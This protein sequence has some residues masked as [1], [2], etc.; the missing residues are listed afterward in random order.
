MPSPRDAF[1][2]PS[3]ARAVPTQRRRM[4]RTVLVGCFKQYSLERV[5]ALVCTESDWFI[6]RRMI[7]DFNRKYCIIYVFLLM[8][9]TDLS[10]TGD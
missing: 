5:C 8:D 7:Y 9:G 4:R 2:M 6:L 1:A 3:R 10:K